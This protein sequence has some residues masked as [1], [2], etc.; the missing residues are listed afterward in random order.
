M[1]GKLYDLAEYVDAHP[2]G[3]FWL[4]CTRGGDVTEAF[5]T[6]HLNARKA[7]AVLKRYYVRDIDPADLADPIFT[8]NDDGLF[9]TLKRRA[10][11]LLGPAEETRRPTPS[12]RRL[13]WAVLLTWAALFAA[14]CTVTNYWV[15]VA[16]SVAAGV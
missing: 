6:H 10:F 11:A 12:M 9:R 14:M 3:A 15:G 2:G 8:F 16:V 5:E 7:D 13:C 4:Q 1:H